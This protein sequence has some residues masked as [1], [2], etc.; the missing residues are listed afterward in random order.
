M[1]KKN[2][3][4]YSSFC[5]LKL[6]LKLFGLTIGL[7]GPFFVSTM[8]KNFEHW[9]CFVSK[10]LEK[11][12]KTGKVRKKNSGG[13]P[14]SCSGHQRRG[15]VFLVTKGN[16]GLV[17]HTEWIY[18]RKEDLSVKILF[19]PCHKWQ[20]WLVRESGYSAWHLHQ[21]TRVFLQLQETPGN[22]VSFSQAQT[23]D[24]D[25]PRTPP[26]PEN[27]N[28]E[29]CWTSHSTCILRCLLEDA[30]F[31]EQNWGSGI[32][33]WTTPFV[34]HLAPRISRTLIPP[35][36]ASPC[37]KL[38]PSLA[39]TVIRLRSL[40]LIRTPFSVPLSF[41]LSFCLSFF[42]CLS[43]N[44]SQFQSQGL[45]S[46]EWGWAAWVDLNS[47]SLS[48]SQHQSQ[49]PRTRMSCMAWPWILSLYL[50]HNTSGRVSTPQNKDDLY[51]WT[52]ILSL[53]PSLSL[54]HNTSSRVSN[55]QNKDELYGLDLNSLSLS[56]SLSVSQHQLQSQPHK[57][58]MSCVLGPELHTHA[59]LGFFRK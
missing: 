4:L 9:K 34:C 33:A 58:R 21:G 17:I 36:N 7:K 28:F 2:N 46:T 49:T 48:A 1:P 25:W 5:G 45:S 56:L 6:F 52:W 19:S 12:S 50:Y 41:F 44:H 37:W 40:N 31:W 8:C 14:V 20:Q 27:L 54:H 47:L 11:W 29:S 57:T 22:C 59:L 26:P 3:W 39:L 23:Q 24:F 38:S 15:W 16:T 55:P 13:N 42:L 32:S 53:S 51:C 43:F 30:W 10:G 18:W 35:S